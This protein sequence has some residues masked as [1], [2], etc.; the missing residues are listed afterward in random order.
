MTYVNPPSA[1]G[2]RRPGPLRPHVAVPDDLRRGSEATTVA[3]LDVPERQVKT[4]IS[5]R[6]LRASRA[7]VDPA[8][9]RSLPAEWSP[10]PAST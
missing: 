8:L 6:L 1:R 7:L 4:G 9:T 3:V 5:H 2:S 10:P